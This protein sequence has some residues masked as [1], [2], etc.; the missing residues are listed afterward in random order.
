MCLCFFLT[1]FADAQWTRS[2]GTSVQVCDYPSH[3]SYLALE[4]DSAGGALLT[5]SDER[6]GWSLFGQKLTNDGIRVWDSS[7]VPLSDST[8][9]YESFLVNDGNGGVF[10]IWNFSADR[11]WYLRTNMQHV[12]SSDSRLWGGEGF[13]LLQQ[14]LFHTRPS[15]CRDGSGGAIV[16]WTPGNDGL[17]QRFDSNGSALWP[18]AGIVYDTAMSNSNNVEAGLGLCADRNGGAF[19]A[20]NKYVNS[21][22]FTCV[23]A[24]KRDASLRFGAGGVQL[25]SAQSY[26]SNF[27]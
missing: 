1:T 25:S 4:S 16:M 19:L 7:G 5:W 11:L 21:S 3:K 13:N 15:C 20:Y 10:I 17:L 6:T 24:V 12:N 26:P 27:V 22:V 2:S 18:G 9:A 8:L 23:Q 14:G